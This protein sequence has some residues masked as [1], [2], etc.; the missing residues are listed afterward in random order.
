MELELRVLRYF[1]AVAEDLHFGRAASRLHISQPALSV[2]IQKLERVL[3][4]ELLTRTSRHVEL[5][6]A[7]LAV[8]DEARRTLAAA[9]RT[10]A[11]ARSAAYGKSGRLTVGFIA[12]AAAE[13]TPVIL[14]EFGQRFPHVDVHMR[15]FAFTDPLA[16][17][18]DGDVDVAFVRTPLKGDQAV[19]SVPLLNEERVLIL[20]D[21]H[22]LAQLPAV[23]VEMV[24][25]QSFVARRAPQDWRDFWLG[26]DHRDGHAVRVGA[27]VSTVDECL[28]AVLT[29]RGIAFT[30][31]SS[32]RY[33]ARPGLAFVP[34][35]G[36]SGST[37]A[38]AW[39]RDSATPLVSA[40]ISA[41]QTVSQS[42]RAPAWP[43]PAQQRR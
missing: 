14:H 37:V 31:A 38:I 24:L 30:Q 33:Y 17:L 2:Q 16:G 12:N 43:V 42:H 1:V 13:L 11:V 35:A 39:R 27:E 4:V 19:E 21:R 10:M 34:V 15:Q 6:D 20:S 29:G 23:T 32:Q 36:L 26:V 28:E 40:F 8:L 3:G 5:T 41:A 18:A 22:P 9:D 25:D 7:G